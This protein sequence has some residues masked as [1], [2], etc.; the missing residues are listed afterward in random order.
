[1]S[2]IGR[3][4][5]TEN[6]RES[7]RCVFSFPG[8][9]RTSWKEAKNEAEEPGYHLHCPFPCLRI[10][11]TRCGLLRPQTTGKHYSG[12]L[13][14]AF[15][16][17]SPTQSNCAGFAGSY[18]MVFESWVSILTFF[19]REVHVP[20]WVSTLQLGVQFRISMCRTH[21]DA[22]ADSQWQV[23]YLPMEGGIVG[24]AL[25]PSGE[26]WAEALFHHELSSAIALWLWENYFD[27]DLIQ[28]FMSSRCLPITGVIRI[29]AAS[30]VAQW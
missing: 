23:W 7:E 8:S 16:H 3:R 24:R 30:P 15:I 18:P 19:L 1:M 29:T 22:V 21:T 6:L 5:V 27:I 14:P 26:C 17:L 9:T 13:P 10:I 28:C 20:S 12:Q 25:D 2:L 4:D 11:A